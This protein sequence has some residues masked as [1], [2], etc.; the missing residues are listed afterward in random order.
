MTC[1][2]HF[3]CSYTHTKDQLPSY[4]TPWN[5]RTD[6]RDKRLSSCTCFSKDTNPLL[7]YNIYLQKPLGSDPMEINPGYS[8]CYYYMQ[9]P[10]DFSR[11][12]QSLEA[13]NILISSSRNHPARKHTRQTEGNSYATGPGGREKSAQGKLAIY[14]IYFHALFTIFLYR[15]LIIL[16]YKTQVNSF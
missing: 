12:D 9:R 7:I 14:I 11:N 1:S 3:C 10:L 5:G 16:L 2:N 15:S 4:T 13:E 6:K 8:E